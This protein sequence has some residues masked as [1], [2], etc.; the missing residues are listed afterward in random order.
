MLHTRTTIS[1]CGA[2]PEACTFRLELPQLIRFQQKKMD[3]IQL[4]GT[5]VSV[6]SPHHYMQLKQPQ[7]AFG[8]HDGQG[9]AG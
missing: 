1:T 4:P 7:N 3:G 9:V 6:P 5:K 8:M 2:W